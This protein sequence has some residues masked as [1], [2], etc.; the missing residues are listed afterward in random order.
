VTEYGELPEELG[1]CLASCH[2]ITKIKES[3]VGDTLE[4]KMFQWTRSEFEETDPSN[5]KGVCSRIEGSLQGGDRPFK[6]GIMKRFDFSS[7]LQRSSAIVQDLDKGTLVGYVKGSPEMIASLCKKETR[8]PSS[9]SHTHTLTLSLSHFILAYPFSSS[10]SQTVPA[11]YF[12]VV[13]ALSGKG[14]RLISLAMHRMEGVPVEDG[15]QLPR[16]TVEEGLEFLGVLVLENRLKRSTK[17]T[18]I[19]LQEALIR[20]VMVT[21]DNP[22]TAVCVARGCSMMP[23]A[24]DVLLVD[25]PMGSNELSYQ[26]L[27]GSPDRAP[28]STDQDLLTWEGEVA[29]TGRGFD[30]VVAQK[31]VL[32]TKKMLRSGTVFARMTPE[33]KRGLVTLFMEEGFTTAMCG[34]GANDCAALKAADVGLSLSEAEASIAAPFTSKDPFIAPIVTLLR[35][36]RCALVGSIAIFKYMACYSLIQFV[37]VLILYRVGTGLGDWQF[38]WID[39]AIIIPLVFLSIFPSSFL[40]C[41]LT[42]KLDPVGRTEAE[43]KLSRN[44]PTGRLVSGSVLVSIICQVKTKN[45]I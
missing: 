9:S 25:S 41:C 39:L 30:W 16:G 36:G 14:Y 32:L 45:G 4:V 38:L 20:T 10:S 2:C 17:E 15:I 13:G 21:G 43:P 3:F 8:T 22:L 40:F 44:P 6:L 31:D 42:K 37:T 35:E 19:S 27:P 24:G 5:S 11:N 33:N 28:E 7:A 26:V 23:A 18:I 29:V 1:H 34:D 12:E